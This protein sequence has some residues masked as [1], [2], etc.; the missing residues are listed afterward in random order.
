[1]DEYRRWPER[2]PGLALPDWASEAWLIVP[3]M[4][5]ADL[6]G[7]V[8]L[9]RPVTPN[10]VDWEVL[11]LLK[12]GSRQAASYLAHARANEALLEAQKFDSFNRMSAF[13]VHDLKNLVA[14]MSLLLKNAERHRANPEFQKDMLDTV[15]H[16]VERMSGLMRQLRSGT[17]PAEKPRAVDVAELMA[18]IAAAK[19]D[20]RVRFELQGARGIRALGHEDRLERV[21]GHLVQNALDATPSDAGRVRV[22]A[23]VDASFAVVEV[24][25]NGVGM[26][27]EFLR[28]RLFRPFQTTKPHGMG[29]G[30][31]E[32][33]QYVSSIGGR[34]QVESTSNSGTTFRVLLPQG[35][36]SAPAGEGFRRV[37]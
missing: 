1:V 13:V 30:V 29:I 19:S 28:D 22:R 2:Y 36:S 11:D 10:D 33:Y 25:D 24:A 26:T 15:A 14:Q 37:A 7:F 32:S 17:T 18:R 4:S 34:L 8:A 27:P 23:F 5:G 3:L 12:T 31:Y 20:P 16:V 35:D 6:V 9:A 21:L